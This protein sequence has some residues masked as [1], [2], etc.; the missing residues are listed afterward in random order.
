[1][2]TLVG[3]Q[4]SANKLTP[5]Q[6]VAAERLLAAVSAGDIVLLKA[7]HGEGRS[8]VLRA[9]QAATGGAL[10]G[11]REFMSVLAGH[12]AA[13]IEE[14]FVSL[15]ERTL[16]RHDFVILDDLHLITAVVND[17]DYPRSGLLDVAVT[18]ILD[19][20]V[21]RRKRVL[22]GTNYGRLPQ[23]IASRA[24]WVET[25]DFAPA[26]YECICEAYLGRAAA[27]RLDFEEILR[28]APGLNAH[29]LIKACIWLR[30]ASELDTAR[31]TEYLLAQNMVS[32]VE[33]EPVEPLDWKDLKGFDD[34]I[35]ALEAKITLPIENHALAA[36]PQLRPK[37]GVLLAGPPG[38]GKTT[39]GRTLAARLKSK[40][41]LI[42]GAVIAGC[43][44]FDSRVRKI[45]DAARKNAPSVVFIDDSDLI[46]ENSDGAGFCRYLLTIL[47]GLESAGAERVCVII[48]ATD[49]HS[50][51]APVLRSGRIEL[52]LETRLPDAAARAA[53]LSER[54]AQ[55]PPPLAAANSGSI[56]HASHGLTGADLRAVVE[57]GKLL[58]A[59]D[60]ARRTA[61]RPVEEYF[62]EAV[63][64]VRSN[65]QNYTRRRPARSVGARE[66]GF[67][68]K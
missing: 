48:T 56:A 32:S 51:P 63:A 35:E 64:T 31:F 45:F 22:F 10:I 50:L 16:D 14:A 23:P 18:A 49:A 11:A 19:R 30:A 28:F 40:F 26:D 67:V 27:S 5:A 44:N 47:D 33:P 38:T 15:M 12:Q 6:R 52:W 57:D 53:I 41:F 2:L 61:A 46:F 65:R 4:S 3:G 59:R 8:T 42:D 58:F 62:L 7:L 68:V 17:C 55:A 34:V 24:F 9:V 29:Q 36:E 37:R 20:A 21:A 43:D 25:Q 66:Y 60:K 39:I 13:A 54:L 1:M